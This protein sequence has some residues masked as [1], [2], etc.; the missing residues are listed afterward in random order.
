MSC[1]FD[2]ELQMISVLLFVWNSLNI[3][4]YFV[5]FISFNHS[6]MYNTFQ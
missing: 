2:S 1:D 6:I 4:Y 3:A 5:V